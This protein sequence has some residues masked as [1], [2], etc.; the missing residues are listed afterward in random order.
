MFLAL[1]GEFAEQPI[2][3]H[4]S[5]SVEMVIL[6]FRDDALHEVDPALVDFIPPLHLLGDRADESHLVLS[7]VLTYESLPHPEDGLNLGCLL[8]DASWSL[9]D[10]VFD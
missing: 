4:L 6:I 7:H 1:N 8:L 10:A 5:L 3:D 9:D 2:V